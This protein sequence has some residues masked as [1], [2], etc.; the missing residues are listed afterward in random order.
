MTRVYIVVEG[1]TEELFVNRALAPVLIPRQI[2]LYPILLGGEGGNPTYV[3]VR[4]NVLL[5]LKQDS[6]ACCTTM[7]D[8]YGLG[9]GFPGVPVPP[10]L[11]KLEMVNHIEGAVKQDVIAQAPRL[12][13][14]VRFIPY[15]QLHE[16]EGLLF[17]DPAAFAKGINQPG[18]AAQLHSIRDDFSNPEDIDD[19]PTTAP[20]KRVIRLCPDYN[21]KINGPQAAIVVSV[22]AMRRECP[23]FRSWLERLEQLTA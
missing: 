7:I 18:L 2:Y 4:R 16:F 22:A 17:S 23:H 10:N 21:K 20:S 8:F 15:L 3:R 6:S 14:D 12:R 1:P 5:Q 9:K 11:S 19:G 13:A